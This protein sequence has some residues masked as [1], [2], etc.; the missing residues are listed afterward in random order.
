MPQFHDA[1]LRQRQFWGFS[2]EYIVGGQRTPD[3][4]LAVATADP[5]ETA[6]D[7]RRKFRVV[8]GEKEYVSERLTFGGCS[9]AIMTDITADLIVILTDCLRLSSNREGELRSHAARLLA[10]I[11]AG[12]STDA[13]RKQVA[14]IQTVFGKTVNDADCMNAVMRARALV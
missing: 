13:L 2:G 1:V 11:K 5:A 10:S 3:A 4:A 7:R 12:S 6:P 8:E 9:G 14:R